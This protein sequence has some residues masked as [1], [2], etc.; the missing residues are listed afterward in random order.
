MYK[1]LITS[2]KDRK[3]LTV[4]L[5]EIPPDSALPS[6]VLRPLETIREVTLEGEHLAMFQKI[7][8]ADKFYIEMGALLINVYEFFV[9]GWNTAARYYGNPEVMTVEALRELIPS[10][11]DKRVLALANWIQHENIRFDKNDEITL[12]RP[13][14]HRLLIGSFQ[15]G[16]V[17]YSR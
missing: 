17:V 1:F 12:S 10:G 14:F 9:L 11:V 2:D 6:H 7:Y 4:F 3:R 5:N 13:Q 16:F 15:S 8:S